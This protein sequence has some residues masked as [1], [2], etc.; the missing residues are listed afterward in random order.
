MA[1]KMIKLKMVII[2]FLFASNVYSQK[3]RVF[4][5]PMVGIQMPLSK[6]SYNGYTKGLLTNNRLE[7][8]ALYGIK[9][10]TTLKNKNIIFLSYQN[11][12]AGYSVKTDSRPCIGY[13]GDF[14]ILGKASAFNNKRLTMGY[15]LVLKRK[16]DKPKTNFY[17]QKRIVLGIAMDFKG[18]ENDTNGNIR[19]VG[20]NRC[21][22]L[23]YLEELVPKRKPFSISI[24]VGFNVE[25]MQGQK[26]RIGISFVYTQGLTTNTLF[27]IDYVTATY[28]DILQL[29]NK[30]SGFSL[31]LYYP[32]RIY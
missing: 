27:Q 21:G 5:T 6:V 10:E 24:P 29:K 20:V 13:N 23:Y 19:L 32:I 3:G 30:G 11:G 15:Q 4:V 17:I 14:S 26:R 25:L 16:E 8:D 7:A 12:M 18:N 22:E 31:H 2:F 9:L 1:I 28:R